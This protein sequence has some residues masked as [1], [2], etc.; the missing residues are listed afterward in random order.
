M[1]KYG[2]NC[3][4][5]NVN[6]DNGHAYLVEIGNECIITN[7]T[8][9]AHDAST[10]LL[11]GKSRI[12]KVKIGNNCFIGLGSVIL[13]SVKIG[14]NCI[15]GAGSVVTKNVPDNSIVAG[16]PAK[17]ISLT[18]DFKKKHEKYITEKPVFDKYWKCK[19]RDEKNEEVRLIGDG[20]GYDE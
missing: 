13:P 4:F 9:L 19:T 5:Y 20:F 18:T 2:E 8:I 10:K 1:L 3:K 12:G 17:V 15:I 16:N 11:I 7:C 14:N 6:I